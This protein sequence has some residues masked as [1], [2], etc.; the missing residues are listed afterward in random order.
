MYVYLLVTG[1]YAICLGVVYVKRNRIF[2]TNTTS[3][4]SLLPVTPPPPPPSQPIEI[5]LQEPTSSEQQSPPQP[6]DS[7]QPTLVEPV[8]TIPEPAPVEEDTGFELLEAIMPKKSI[9]N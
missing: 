9:K 5:Q 6:S 8:I 4:L 1:L 7:P 3:H 2:N